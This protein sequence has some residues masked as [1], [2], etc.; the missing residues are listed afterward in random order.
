MLK[1]WDGKEWK[2]VKDS[3][4]SQI[5]QIFSSSFTM[6]CN[7]ILDLLTSFLQ[8]AVKDTKSHQKRPRTFTDVVRKFF[9]GLME[10]RY[11]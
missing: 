8:S 7:S 2:T 9:K 4:S 5:D 10:G 11:K 6:Y 1:D 3:K